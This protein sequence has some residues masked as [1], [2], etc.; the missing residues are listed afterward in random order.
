M[1]SVYTSLF[2][3]GA[4]PAA[5]TAAVTSQVAG[6]SSNFNTMTGTL[7]SSLSTASALSPDI[8]G[9]VNTSA[10]TNALQDTQNL[11]EMCKNL[12]PADCATKQ[13]QQQAAADAAQLKFYRDT[14]DA[15]IKTY[16]DVL[17]TV[18]AQ[19]ASLQMEKDSALAAGT[20]VFK[21]DSIFPLY[22]DLISRINTDISQFQAS[23]PYLIPSTTTS[24]SSSGSAK[25]PYELP[26]ATSTVADY[27]A[28]NDALIFKYDQMMGNPYDTKRMERS[29]ERWLTQKFIPI[30]FLM[31]LVVSVIWGGIVL[32]NIYVEAEKDFIGTR[33]WYFIHGMLGF[34]AVL[35]YSLISPPF[36]VSG[37]FPW[38]PR[39]AVNE[40]E[41]ANVPL[42]IP[43]GTGV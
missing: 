35:A 30:A 9:M 8:A 14:L 40:A 16:T 41:T 33:V 23:V 6:L 5:D 32:S 27:T 21:G 25:P 13:A 37:I 34:P 17:T 7:S 2:G 24:G 22:A 11:Q 38:T 29:G 43:P 39:K 20:L 28:E 3:G 31:T 18:K 42:E 36:W 26:S 4:T 12:S 19:Q 10:L 15:S 1:S